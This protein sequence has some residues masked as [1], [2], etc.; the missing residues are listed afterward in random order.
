MD[1][2]LPVASD[3]I[4]TS[5]VTVSCK[6]INMLAACDS[7]IVIDTAVAGVSSM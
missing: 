6:L 4:H 2:F 3:V 5:S 7:R 1:M